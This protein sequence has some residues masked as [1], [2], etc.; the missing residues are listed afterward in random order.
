MLIVPGQGLGIGA[1]RGVLWH[2]DPLTVKGIVMPAVFK[3]RLDPEA[4]LEIEIRGDRHIAGVEQAVDVAPQQQSVPHLVGTAVTIGPDVGRLQRR[5]GPFPR[6][7]ATPPV[8]V[9]H[10]HAEGALPQTRAN[11]MR[12]AEPRLLFCNAGEWTLAQAVVDRLP[13][14]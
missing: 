6:H 1:L 10:Q 5:Q 9:G 8:N 2:V 12:L 3:L 4:D 7:G 14:G 11:K 13:Q